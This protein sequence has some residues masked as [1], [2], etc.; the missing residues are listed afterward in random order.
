MKI[1][2][3]LSGMVC[4]Y[5]WNEVPRDAFV[6]DSSTTARG[7]KH[8]HALFQLPMGLAPLPDMTEVPFNDMA[9]RHLLASPRL[10]RQRS[11]RRASRP[12]E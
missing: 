6:I 1:C 3:A 9:T 5:S 11:L 12:A 8:T 2:A 4:V 10:P 7:L